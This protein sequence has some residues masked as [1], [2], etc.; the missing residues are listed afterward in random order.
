MQ[1]LVLVDSYGAV[2]R[3]HSALVVSDEVGLLLDDLLLH[4]AINRN[5]SVLGQVL[6]K[7]T[8]K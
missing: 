1:L 6:L 7:A 3:C 5:V 4:V 8:N 2:E